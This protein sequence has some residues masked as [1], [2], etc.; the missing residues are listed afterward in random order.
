MKSGA[1]IKI[2]NKIRGSGLSGAFARFFA[3]NFGLIVGRNSSVNRI[4]LLPVF[5]PPV[6]WKPGYIFF[7]QF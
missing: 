7:I 3:E 6:S 1:A 4:D 2:L 5:V